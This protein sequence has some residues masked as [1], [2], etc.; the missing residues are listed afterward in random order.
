MGKQEKR[1]KAHAAY[2]DYVMSYLDEATQ[3]A[4]NKIGLELLSRF[5]FET[6][7][8]LESEQ[9][10]RRLLCEMKR[11]RTS[12]VHIV[13]PCEKRR[14]NVIHFELVRNGRV[15]GRS[16]SVEVRYGPRE[17]NACDEKG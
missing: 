2:A 3:A 1:L 15:Q 13:T 4:V 6:E 14:S 5:G 8:F 9:V 11:K 7:G 17:E 12:L 10:R 16:E